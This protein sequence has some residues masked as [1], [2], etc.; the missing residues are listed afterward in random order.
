MTTQPEG[1]DCDMQP[2]VSIIRIRMAL[3][4]TLADRC[5][6][7][8]GVQ[9]VAPVWHFP[10]HWLHNIHLRPLPRALRPDANRMTAPITAGSDQS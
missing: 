6:L 2:A 4:A 10:N 1:D 8:V 3:G 9:R 5:T 7:E